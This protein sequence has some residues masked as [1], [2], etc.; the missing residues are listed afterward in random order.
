MLVSLECSFTD[1][2]MIDKERF[3]YLIWMSEYD[4]GILNEQILASPVILDSNVHI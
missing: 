4:T 2:I 3:W 1:L